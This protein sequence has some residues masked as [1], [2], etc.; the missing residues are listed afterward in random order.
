MVISYLNLLLLFI[1][2][3]YRN[4]RYK[5]VINILRF[6]VNYDYSLHIIV[7]NV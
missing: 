4:G 3:Q 6:T 1:Y 2:Y 5:I 7:I